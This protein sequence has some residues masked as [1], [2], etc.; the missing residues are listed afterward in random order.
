MTL[1]QF[2]ILHPDHQDRYLLAN[3]VCIASRETQENCLL[4]FQ[5]DGFYVEIHYHNHCG[6]IIRSRPFENTEELYPYLEQV[7]ISFLN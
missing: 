1:Q 4:L 6:A 2:N 7:D 5:L 3:G